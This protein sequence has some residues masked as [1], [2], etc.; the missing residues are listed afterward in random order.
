MLD[1][2]RLYKELRSYEEAREKVIQTSIRVTRLSKSA[3]YSLIRGDLEAARR[4]LK[5]METAAAEL[6][7]LIAKYPMFYNNGAQ[8]LQEYVEAYSLWVFLEERRLP[9]LEEVGVDVMTYLMGIADI[10]GELGR[11][12]N[13]ELVKKNVGAA[14]ELK[15]AVEKLYLDMLSLEPRDFEL[16]KK[17]DYISNQANWASEKLFYAATCHRIHEAGGGNN[18]KA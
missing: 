9:T 10:A 8:G 1:V 17:V 18:E 5:D 6:K 11:K 12:I 4:H 16:R 14:E 3:I 13:E 15:A 2:N 7:E